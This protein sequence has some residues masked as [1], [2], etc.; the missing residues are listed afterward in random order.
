[1]LFLK[2]KQ[3]HLTNVFVKS[4]RLSIAPLKVLINDIEAKINSDLKNV[5]IEEL[6]AHIGT[7]EIDMTGDVQ[8]ISSPKYHFQIT[9]KGV[10]V[11]DILDEGNWPALL[12]GAING[13]FSGTGASFKPE[14]ML[15]NLK[16]EGDFN[17]S[18]AKVEKLNILSLIID[19]LNFI[20]GLGGIIKGSLPS[21]IANKLDTD[22]T[23]LTKAQSKIR[24]ENKVIFITDAQV[25][26][27]LLSATAQ[28]HVDF[29]LAV[30][31]DVKTYLA[32]DLSAAL[33]KKAKP[34]KGLLDEQNR[35]Y[36]PGKVS[37]QVPAISYMPE[38]DYIRSKVITSESTDQISKQLD[39]VLEKNP[40]VKNILNSLLGDGNSEDSTQKESSKEI[41]NN[42]L[43]SILK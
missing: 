26:S 40:G 2:A 10:K 24:L 16:G 21:D 35:L 13:Q 28:G 7:G 34:L 8:D 32:V 20:P 37:G 27:N 1:M 39:K 23:V 4:V 18:D 5:S 38:M 25:E 12:N 6:Q 14:E 3:I 17:L 11:Q 42:L 43:K 30:D 41:I 22:T 36:I 9:F 19:K 31:V 33:T 15:S 29:A